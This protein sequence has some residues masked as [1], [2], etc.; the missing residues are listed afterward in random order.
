MIIPII[1]AADKNY[2]MPMCVTITSILTTKKASSCCKFYLLVP[3]K[4]DEATY[5]KFSEL[6]TKYPENTID[7]LAMGNHFSEASLSISHITTP[8]Y[9]RLSVAELLLQHEKALYLDTDTI[10]CRDIEK[11]FSFDLADNYL[12][13]VKAPG[14]HTFSDG[15]KSY[16]EKSGLPSVDQYVNA[17]VL[18]M[19]LAA[20]RKDNITKRFVELIQEPLPSQDQD[21]LNRVCYDR[22]SFLPFRYNLFA[23]RI[24]ERKVLKK[25]FSENEIEQ[26][27]SHPAIIHFAHEEKPWDTLDGALHLQWWKYAMQSPYAQEV[28]NKMEILLNQKNEQLDERTKQVDELHM[29]VSGLRKRMSTSKSQN[30]KLSKKLL[31]IKASKSYR[32]GRIITFLPRKIRAFLH[33]GKN[34]KKKETL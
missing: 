8:T 20:I 22:I 7:F 33:E 25:V 27:I 2:T 11:L 28:W 19:N 13:G 34:P 14:Y 18:L 10:V 29:Q 12:G 16:C 6:V 17:G 30:E 32:V 9:Y 23:R 26:A 3:E 15:G 5:N 1:L 21:I 31:S 4:P 24:A